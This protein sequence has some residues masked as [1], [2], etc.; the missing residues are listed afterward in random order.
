MPARIIA[1]TTPQTQPTASRP[2][3]S[4]GAGGILHLCPRAKQR[5]LALLSIE[6]HQRPDNLL[7]HVQLVCGITGVKLATCDPRGVA[8]PPQ[9][10]FS[11]GFGDLLSERNHGLLLSS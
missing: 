7:H 9:C 6:A 2:G 8:L 3:A 1:R 5:E 4:S 11:L 10:E